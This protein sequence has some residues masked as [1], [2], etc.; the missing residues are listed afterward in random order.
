MLISKIGECIENSP[1]SRA[2]IKK[3]MGISTNTLSNWSTGKS[4]PSAENLFKLSRLL[5][6]TVED[7]YDYVEDDEWV[8]FYHYLYLQF[9]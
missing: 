6:K 9:Y 7:L 3:V 2:Y 8:Y 5:G 4:I 1:Y